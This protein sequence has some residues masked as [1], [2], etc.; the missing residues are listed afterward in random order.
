MKKLLFLILV[1][2]LVLFVGCVGTR[3]AVRDIPEQEIE[4]AY[5]TELNIHDIMFTA[6]APAR[7]NDCVKLNT[8]SF[9][10]GDVFYLV[11]RFGGLHPDENDFVYWSYSLDINYNTEFLAVGET[12]HRFLDLNGPDVG[13]DRYGI[14]ELFFMEDEFPPGLYEL[15][16]FIYDGLTHEIAETFVSFSLLP[17]EMLMNA[18]QL[19]DE[20]VGHGSDGR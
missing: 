10:Y 11:V 3:V 17:R 6:E 4:P 1:F 16:I 15:H 18:M 20:L 9:H 13:R 2:I 12:A 14:V 8:D 19:W 7:Y 5:E